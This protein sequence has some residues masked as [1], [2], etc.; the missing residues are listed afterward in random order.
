MLRS[1]LR[2]YART[3]PRGP[4]GW[5]AAVQLGAD[6]VVLVFNQ[7]P[8]E[9]RLTDEKVNLVLSAA[10]SSAKRFIASST[11]FTGLASMRPRG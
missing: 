2:G 7:R 1:G 10:S 5:V 9:W 8:A 6:A 3:I 4:A 11:L